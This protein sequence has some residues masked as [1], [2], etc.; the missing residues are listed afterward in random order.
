VISGRQP[1]EWTFR[2]GA[3]GL[4]LEL[5]FHR[6]FTRLLGALTRTLL[7]LRLRLLATRLLGALTRTLLRLRLRLLA[8]RLLGALTRTLLRLRLVLRRIYDWLRDPELLADPLGDLDD[9]T[10]HLVAA[11]A[12]LLPL[13]DLTLEPAPAPAVAAAMAMVPATILAMMPENNPVNT[14]RLLKRWMGDVDPAGLWAG[15]SSTA[16]AAAAM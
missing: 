13:L 2:S 12:D 1:S 7:R 14:V 3:L 9:L 10:G 15:A 16:S 4:D 11:L 5:Q 6:H 8:T